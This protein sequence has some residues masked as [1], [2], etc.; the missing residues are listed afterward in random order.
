MIYG[1][2][3]NVKILKSSLIP[4]G[5]LWC[6]TNAEHEFIFCS[7]IKLSLHVS[8]LPSECANFDGF[9]TNAYSSFVFVICNGW[10]LW[11]ICWRLALSIKFELALLDDERPFDDDDDGELCWLFIWFNKEREFRLSDV[12]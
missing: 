8:S 9:I 6:C 1:E 12:F 10:E 7:S 4:N 5:L 11:R 2:S 3:F